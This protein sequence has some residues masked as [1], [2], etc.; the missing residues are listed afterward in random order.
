M[1]IYA[2]FGNL[3]RTGK[4]ASL[5]V[6]LHSA[7]GL[8]GRA[9]CVVNFKPKKSHPIVQKLTK[10]L[11]IHENC[12]VALERHPCITSRSSRLRIVFVFAHFI[13]NKVE[14]GRSAIT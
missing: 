2:G 5:V 12:M 4:Q 8:Q 13:I 11:D 14:L 7:P 10:S 1:K 9:G 3:A 6:T